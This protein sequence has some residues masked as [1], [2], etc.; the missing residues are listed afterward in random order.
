VLF[1]IYFGIIGNINDWYMLVWLWCCEFLDIILYLSV[2]ELLCKKLKLE[3]YE[4]SDSFLSCHTM[5]M[6]AFILW[7]IISRRAYIQPGPH[8]QIIGY[9]NFNQKGIEFWSG[10]I[11]SAMTHVLVLST[12]V[13][14]N[15][16][17]K[18]AVMADSRH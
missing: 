11:N 16:W 14:R 8:L 10:H 5:H 1:H 4:L 9:Q 13:R 6:M 12:K 7:H 18:W 15:E 17:L 3:L 2:A